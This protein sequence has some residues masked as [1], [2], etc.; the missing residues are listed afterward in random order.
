MVDTD[1]RDRIIER[2]RRELRRR[3][4]IPDGILPHYR[5]TVHARVR[6]SDPVGARWTPVRSP[7]RPVRQWRPHISSST[8]NGAGPG[9]DDPG[10]TVAPLGCQRVFVS[11]LLLAAGS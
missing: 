7:A 3:R 10:P 1:T 11:G 5:G 4:G 6:A 8:E 9:D 2:V